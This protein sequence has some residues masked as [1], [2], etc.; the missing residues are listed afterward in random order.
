MS[1][2]KLA[3]DTLAS[4]N[5]DNPSK[6]MEECNNCWRKS[7]HLLFCGRCK[8]TKYCDKNC[9]RTHWPQHKKSCQAKPQDVVGTT[10]K[11]AT[12]CHAR[13]DDLC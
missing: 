6:L 11:M 7:F 9:Q 8:K 10:D 4:F 5:Q 12:A 3:E 13:L 2:S 1:V